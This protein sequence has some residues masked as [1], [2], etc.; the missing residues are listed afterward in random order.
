MKSE[1]TDVQSARIS[2]IENRSVKVGRVKFYWI[3]F[4]TG[5][6]TLISCLLIIGRSIF[7]HLSMANVDGIM[8]WWANNLLSLV[9]VKTRVVGTTNFPAPGRRVIVMCNHSSLYDVPVAIA[10]LDTSFRFVAKKELFNIP[11]F[12]SALRR[13]R[14]LSI[15][16]QNRSQALKDLQQA[17]K[18]MLNGITLWISPEG[19][20][21]KD[22]Q[23]KEFKRGGFHI[24][25]ETKALIVPVV[26]KG[27]HKVQ[28]G[29]DLQLYSNQEVEVEICKPVDTNDYNSENRRELINQVR[30][31]ML[32]AIG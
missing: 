4:M 16:R 15:D 29:D 1:Y 14:F 31:R 24:A 7:H 8:K 32:A 12:G 3:A 21:S 30:S 26:I 22:G 25:I 2:N 27:I 6:F 19:T 17:K 13:G 18:H 28:A 23:L 9:K 10:A 5:A 20:R 11:I